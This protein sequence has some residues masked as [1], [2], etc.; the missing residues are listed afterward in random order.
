MKNNFFLNVY[1]EN[2]MKK[3]FKTVIAA[4]A[5]VGIS[6]AA[7]AGDGEFDLTVYHMNDSHSYVEPVNTFIKAGGKK[8]LAQIGGMNP[9][10]N[11]L[12]KHDGENVIR[13]H[14]GDF[15]TGNGTYF[16]YYHGRD[17]YEILK[18]LRFDALVMGNH[19]FD[20]GNDFI[21]E[22]L[23]GLKSGPHGVPVVTANVVVP[24]E[25]RL[26]PLLDPYII[27]ERG[28]EKI[29]VIGLTSSTKVVTSSKPDKDTQFLDEAETANKIVEEL[30]KK[31]INK[32]IGLTHIGLENDVEVVKKYHGI[33]VLVTGDSHTIM[34][35]QLHKIGIPTIDD[36]PLTLKNMDGNNVC[37]VQA[38]ST[39][40]LLGKLNV[41]FDKDGNV[42]SCSGAPQVIVSQISKP[43]SDP[44]NEE[45]T[46][47]VKNELS[48]FDF[49]SFYDSARDLSN[50]KINGYIDEIHSK[51][52]YLGTN[53]NALCQTRVPGEVCLLTQTEQN[54]GCEVCTA[55]SAVLAKNFPDTVILQNA[56]NYRTFM[57]PG[58]VY[59]SDV[60]NVLAF[61]NNLISVDI[62]GTELIK[63]LNGGIDSYMK[64]PSRDGSFPTGYGVRFDL[65]LTAANHEYISN[66]EYKGPK[67]WEPVEPDKKYT[68]ILN[69]Y[70]AT[71]ADGYGYLKQL[72]DDQKHNFKNLNK[73]IAEE[74]IAVL[75]KDPKI[76]KLPISEMFVKKLKKK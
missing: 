65:D 1:Q 34:G 11:Y 69:E 36:Y 59:D 3:I 43:N 5:A 20:H 7:D 73:L 4:A 35:Y 24:R 6:S 8:Y 18:E 55:L 62:S 25:N 57:W 72:V 42:I 28:G 23:A 49:V 64:N 32:F 26:T 60:K 68:V 47:A 44:L 63:L 27:L 19:E 71:G 40:A 70:I 52:E 61:A 31:G 14:A 41:K 17:D 13:L 22:I 76:E 12:V 37:V 50:D 16:N 10:Y 66:V 75:K 29:A 74:T 48:K 9:I 30:R 53:D 67:G 2:L 38:G 56:G 51:L 58:K 46:A 39:A 54:H 15:Q 45:E 21:A 33:D